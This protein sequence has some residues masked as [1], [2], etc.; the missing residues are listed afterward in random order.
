MVV[1][2]SALVVFLLK[3]PGWRELGNHLVN[4]VSLDMVVKEAT[5]I[6]WKAYGV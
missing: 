4:A 3:E 1:D 5:N 2:A 6:I